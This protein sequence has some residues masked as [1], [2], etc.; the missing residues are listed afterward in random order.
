MQLPEEHTAAATCVIQCYMCA[1][2]P[3]ADWTVAQQRLLAP[4]NTVHDT[5]RADHLA[6]DVTI[7]FGN[8]GNSG[9]TTPSTACNVMPVQQPPG[10][11]HPSGSWEGAS[12]NPLTTQRLN[13]ILETFNPAKNS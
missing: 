7:V 11:N 9:P 10:D 8:A 5:A 12:G 6:H 3:C 4:D 13:Y 2:R 1:S